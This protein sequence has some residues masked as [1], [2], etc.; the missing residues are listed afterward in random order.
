MT[1]LRLDADRQ[2][3]AGAGAA[4]PLWATWGRREPDDLHTWPCFAPGGGCWAALRVGRGGQPARVVVGR[5]D[6]VEIESEPVT[7]VPIYLQ[8][9]PNARR[10]AVVTQ[11]QDALELLVWGVDAT[12]PRAWLT[13]TP[14]FFSWLDDDA[15][16]AHVGR[17]GG[18]NDV[19]VTDGRT[20]QVFPGATA[21]FCVPVALPAGVVWVAQ[22]GGRATVLVTART[23]VPS[24]EL[25]VVD[26][27]A[28]ILPVDDGQALRAVS[29]DGDGR[30]YG[31]LRVL[32]PRT[33]RSARISDAPML[34]FLPVPRGGGTVV[35][36]RDARTGVVAFARI[37]ANGGESVVA[38]VRPS[39]DLRFWLRFFEQFAPSH[40]LV[41]PE[42]TALVV[43]G[44]LPEDPDGDSHVFRFPL[45]G[46]EPVDLGAGPFACFAPP[47]QGES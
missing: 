21:A 12:P 8:W 46:G 38:R 18:R 10:V 19:V 45:D 7:G 42:G 35:A 28:A 4:P 32:D 37:L 13:A 30:T 24:R 44:T 14:L 40:P 25:E 17:M 22:H 31:D 16:V 9:S 6:G 27:L 29:T 41:D 39:R 43:A 3:V 23:G 15:V 2:V 1:L 5:P 36:R 11:R 26:G 34:A 47:A 33:G 20:T